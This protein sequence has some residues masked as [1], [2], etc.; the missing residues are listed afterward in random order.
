[1]HVTLYPKYNNTAINY[2]EAGNLGA[3]G[4]EGYTAQDKASG[5][6]ST[7]LTYGTSTL[8]DGSEDV[9]TEVV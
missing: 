9:I 1:M 7:T 2:L 4:H 8:S 5:R 3:N 6:V